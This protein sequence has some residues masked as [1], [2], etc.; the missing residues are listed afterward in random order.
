M[1]VK[2]K[3]ELDALDRMVEGVVDGILSASDSEII[4]EV[5]E[6]YGDEATFVADIDNVFPCEGRGYRP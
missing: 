2:N 6:R 3:V 5:R 1:S 4:A